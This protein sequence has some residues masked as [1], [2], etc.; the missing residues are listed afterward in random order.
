[1]KILKR[2]KILPCECKI[3]HAVFQPKWR[4]LHESVCSLA[5]DTVNCPMCK[6]Y[7]DVTFERG[8]TDDGSNNYF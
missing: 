5:K 6:A 7:N 4:N 2:P 1:M 8:E 3:C